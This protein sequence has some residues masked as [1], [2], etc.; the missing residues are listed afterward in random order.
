VLVICARQRSEILDGMNLMDFMVQKS[1]RYDFPEPVTQADVVRALKG[2]ESDLTIVADAASHAMDHVADALTPSEFAA[3]AGKQY[4][5]GV[6]PVPMPT[7][8]KGLTD[9]MV[10]KGEILTRDDPLSIA[11]SE[12]EPVGPGRRGFFIGMAVAEGQTLLGPGKD[13]FRDGLLPEERN[14]FQAAVRFSV[15]RN[16]NAKLAG[17]GAALAKADPEIATARANPS[18]F[19]TLGFDIASGLFG[20]PARGAVGNTATGPGSLGIRDLLNQEGQNGF[21]S[22]IAFHLGPPLRLR[23]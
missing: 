13:T 23:G 18:P 3:K 7:L 8:K 10:A 1:E 16:R 5:Q 15:D 9:G 14:G 22:A 12:R 17:V 21:N 6:P 20:D 2:Y 4:P 19:F 11:L